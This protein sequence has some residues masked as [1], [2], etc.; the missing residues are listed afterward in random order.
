MLLFLSTPNEEFDALRGE[1]GFQPVGPALEE[2][3][4]VP[5]PASQ[6]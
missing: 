1:R 6:A 2:A 4:P 3:N 5:G